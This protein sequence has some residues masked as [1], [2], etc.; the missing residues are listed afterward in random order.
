[1]CTTVAKFD[2][3]K[4][5]LLNND[6]G[7]SASLLKP[8]GYKKREPAFMTILKR[9]IKPG[10][11]AMDIGANLGFVTLYMCRGVG[12]KGLIYAVE[13]SS[14][15]YEILNLNIK[16]N[17]FGSIAS[18]ENLA[19]S[20]INGDVEFFMSDYS[21]LG[22]L[23]RFDKTNA[24][25][26]T[27][28]CVNLDSYLKDKEMPEFYKMDIEGAEVNVLNGM[29]SVLRN[30]VPGTKILME[31]HPQFYKGNEMA[32]ALE[33][34]LDVNF[35]FK[36]VISAAIPCP[37]LFANKGYKPVEIYKSGAWARG[38]FV[39][40]SADDAILF[41]AYPHEEYVKARGKS[42]PKIV[43]SIM[44]EKR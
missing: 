36:Y 9:E 3:F 32:L 22:S 28:K 31:V 8:G 5:H 13:P 37:K 23:R 26:A 27:V 11:V 15:N 7:I 40:I 19:V 20:D 38:V 6:P 30:S 33:S 43:R 1:M 42:T 44:L 17:G 10:S 35:Y 2:G 34:V 39:D 12:D 4:M 41:A 14:S 24:G 25:S 29:S 16:L 18:A 21:N